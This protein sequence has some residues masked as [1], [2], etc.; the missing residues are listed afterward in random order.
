[1]NRR[2]VIS[3]LALFFA[4]PATAQKYPERR[5]VRE[6]N[7][8]YER[9]A[10]PEG[11]VAYRRALE[12][13]PESYEAAYNLGKSLYKQERWD[14]AAGLFAPLAAD[15]S[16]IATAPSAW[17]D[18]GN[19]LVKQR[20]LQE[21]LEAYKQSLRLNPGD[22]QAKFNLAY[23][24]KLL[25]NEQD[26]NDDGGGGGG[27]QPPQPQPEQPQPQPDPQQDPGEA[28]GGMSRREA[29]QMLEAMQVSEE[30]TRQRKEGEK[31]PVVRERGEKNW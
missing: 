11:E 5:L 9:K 19:A 13:A 26:K 6:G 12:K 23:V 7:R 30:Q 3:L 15:S 29:E 21:A 28:E 18:L 31:V 4:L 10:Y 8:H 17:Y 1:M 20:K 14:E 22:Q 27:D 2:I 24:Q 25:E 16:R